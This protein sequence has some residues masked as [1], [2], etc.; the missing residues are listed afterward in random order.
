MSGYPKVYRNGK[1]V[2]KWCA[3]PKQANRSVSVISDTMQPLRHMATGK[4]IDSKSQFRNE[5]KASGC[6]EIGNDPIR[7]RQRIELD[8]RQRADDIRRTIYELKNG[9][10]G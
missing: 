10:R 8:R 7:P 9:R 5:T 3:E 6:V 2:P 1:L 4:V